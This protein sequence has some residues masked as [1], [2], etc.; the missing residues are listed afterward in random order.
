VTAVYVLFQAGSGSG[1]FP[2][3]NVNVFPNASSQFF[4]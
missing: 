4:A 3:D 2:V 1:S